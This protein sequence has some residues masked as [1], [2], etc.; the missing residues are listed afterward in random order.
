[1]KYIPLNGETLAIFGLIQAEAA[2]SLKSSVFQFSNSDPILVKRI[3]KYFAVI[4]KVPK[5]SWSVYVYYWKPNFSGKE[6]SINNYWQNF[7][8]IKINS[9]KQGTSYRLSEHSKE[10]GVASLRLN[11]KIMA[12]L[13]LNFLYKV[14]RPLVEK[15]SVFAGWYLK[16]LFDGDGTLSVHKGKFCFAGL[17]F[18]PKSDELDHYHKVLA[19][20][21]IDFDKAHLRKTNRRCIFFGHWQTIYK[22][23]KATNGKL[24]L[25]DR[26]KILVRAFLDNQYVVPLLR[27]KLLKGKQPITINAYTKLL[28]YGKRNSADCLKRLRDLKLISCDEEKPFKYYLTC[29]GEEFL[30]FVEKLGEIKN[31]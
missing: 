5:T 26:N 10:F 3:L 19:L 24:F 31:D 25:N 23:L 30:D 28:G 17:A 1:P 7:L 22:L 18:N 11:N 14:V 27:L 8:G 15:S 2:K 9:V 21:N 6:Y 16:G 29:E 20:F 13:I 4:W 12:G